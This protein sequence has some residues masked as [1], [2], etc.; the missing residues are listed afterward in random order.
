MSSKELEMKAR[1]HDLSDVDVE[2][3][4]ELTEAAAKE[5]TIGYKKIEDGVVSGYKKIEDGVV[6]GYKKIETGVGRGFRQGHRCLCQDLVRQRRGNGG[7]SQGKTFR[8]G[9]G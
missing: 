9:K 7:G 2:V 4:G 1:E 6:N 3:V 8:Q 5:V